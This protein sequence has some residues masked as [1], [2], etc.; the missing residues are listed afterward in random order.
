MADNELRSVG[1]GNWIIGIYNPI[2]EIGPFRGILVVGK[3]SHTVK[4]VKD[5]CIVSIPSP[6]ISYCVN[7]N[8]AP[9]Y[10]TED[11]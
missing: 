8:V 7:I 1:D 6:N 10:K 11:K 4:S 9:N 5:I 2:R 3:E